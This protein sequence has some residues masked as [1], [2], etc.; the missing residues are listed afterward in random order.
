MCGEASASYVDLWKSRHCTKFF[1][2]ITLLLGMVG[3][4]VS[5]VMSKCHST[6]HAQSVGSY[7]HPSVIEAFCLRQQLL[8]MLLL[9]VE[10]CCAACDNNSNT[11]STRAMHGVKP[12]A[13]CHMPRACEACGSK[14]MDLAL[15]ALALSKS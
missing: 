4:C 5:H 9:G 3:C 11:N 7:I 6:S 15:W 10:G 1:S 13:I 14:G 12:Y 2:G 8:G